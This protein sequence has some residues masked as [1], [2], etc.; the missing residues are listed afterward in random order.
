MDQ[1]P[2]LEPCPFC[3]LHLE[4]SVELSTR[5]ARQFIHPQNDRLWCV[6]QSIMIRDKDPERVAAWNRRVPAWRPISEVADGFV[7]LVSRPDDRYYYE[8]T[9]AFIDATGKW[10]VFRSEGGCDPLPFEPTHY[11]KLPKRPVA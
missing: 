1:Q 7:Y 2:T 3:G 5:K 10:R 4:H 9:T 6:A 8:P 11:M